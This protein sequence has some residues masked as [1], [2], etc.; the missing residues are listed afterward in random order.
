MEC[1]NKLKKGILKAIEEYESV[2]NICNQILHVL[3]ISIEV[4]VK[5]DILTVT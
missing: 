2:G 5:V 1:R 4:A 3:F